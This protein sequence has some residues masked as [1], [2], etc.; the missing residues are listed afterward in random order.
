LGITGGQPGSLGRHKGA[1]PPSENEIALA[2]AFGMTGGQP[3]SLGRQS[4]AGPPSENPI[5]E[6]LEEA[7][8][9]IV[10][11]SIRPASAVVAIDFMALSLLMDRP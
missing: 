8:A 1:G 7:I 11:S 10:P 5:P 9:E 4:G 3:G 6:V 2:F